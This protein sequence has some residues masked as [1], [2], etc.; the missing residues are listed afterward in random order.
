MNNKDN[1]SLGK[2]KEFYIVPG[3]SLFSLNDKNNLDLQEIF[4]KKVFLKNLTP[5][6][7][8]HLVENTII[9]KD[10]NKQT[11]WINP[12][13]LGKKKIYIL[14]NQYDGIELRQVIGQEIFGLGL[15]IFIYRN[16]DQWIVTE[17]LSGLELNQKEKS[18]RAAI[19]KAKEQIDFFG[20]D[21]LKKI[22][23]DFTKSSG[24]VSECLEGKNDNQ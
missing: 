13:K 1:I 21:N 11:V 18:K 22:I 20:L 3:R 10:G 4:N 17:M 24:T 14:P 2:S 5:C 6:D 23:K 15:S 19:Q 12:K 8:S 16:V 9:N 7:R